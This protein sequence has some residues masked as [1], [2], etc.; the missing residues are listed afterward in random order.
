MAYA[1]QQMSSR[2]IVAIAVVALLHAIIGYAFITGLAYNVVKKAVADLKTFDVDEPPPPPEQKP[3]PPPPEQKVEPPPMVAP[4]PIVST[5]T[6]IAPPIQTVQVAPPVVITPTAPPAPPPPPPKPSVA[7]SASPRGSIGTWVSSDDY[8]SRALREEK[9][10]V[11]G[12]SFDISADGR[13]SN[14]Q[15]TSSSGTPELDQ[16]TCAPFTRRARYNPA[17]DSAGNKIAQNGQSQ[18]IRWQIPKE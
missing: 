2:R 17:Q 16:A 6:V 4:P 5:P 13:V 9:E 12:I 1:D 8:P 10:G 11:V 18:R 14:C 15:V 7:K 3:P